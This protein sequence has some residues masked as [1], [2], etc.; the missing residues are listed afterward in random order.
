MRGAIGWR[1]DGFNNLPPWPDD[2]ELDEDDIALLQQVRERGEIASAPLSAPY[3]PAW[4]SH[5][6]AAA[7]VH[8]LP[9]RHYQPAW[10]LEERLAARKV[11]ERREAKQ[12]KR[13]EYEERQHREERRLLAEAEKKL[14]AERAKRHRAAVDAFERE[15][16]ARKDAERERA[17]AESHRQYEIY[18]Q[19]HE[20]V[21]QRQTV[22]ERWWHL[23][24]GHILF[25]W[26]QAFV[27]VEEAATAFAPYAGIIFL[28][29]QRN[30]VGHY[31]TASRR[32]FTL[33]EKILAVLAVNKTEYI[34]WDRLKRET[35]CD[36]EIE[37]R[38]CL[39]ALIPNELPVVEQEHRHAS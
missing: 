21:R 35:G 13:F 29:Q 6:S 33:E 24:S 37:L 3:I 19:R 17:V 36:D 27:R 30:G 7:P 1:H 25:L 22:L 34:N 12:R 32:P 14:A 15:K 23:D 11:A 16:Q 20:V 28:Y 39:R 2:F 9:Q 5:Y 4:R 18:M 38:H 8:D 26:D 10:K 31:I